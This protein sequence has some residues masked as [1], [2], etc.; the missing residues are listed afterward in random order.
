MVSA[1]LEMK[2]HDEYDPSYDSTDEE[3]PTPVRGIVSSKSSEAKKQTYIA[4]S[5]YGLP[6]QG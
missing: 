6:N 5:D 2:A 3:V 1:S 4:S